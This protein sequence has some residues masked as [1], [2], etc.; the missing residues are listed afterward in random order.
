MRL[1]RY[2]LPYLFM[3]ILTLL[4]RRAGGGGVALTLFPHMDKLAHALAFAGVMGAFLVARLPRPWSCKWLAAALAQVF[5][6]AILDELHQSR[7]PGRSADVWDVAADWAG[8]L[9]VALWAAWGA[10][11]RTQSYPTT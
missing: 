5:A 1:V 10:R 2:A 9:L 7:V 11:R 4:S 8:A 3:A 6:F